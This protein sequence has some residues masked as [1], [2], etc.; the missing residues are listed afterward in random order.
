MRSEQSSVNIRMK[1]GELLLTVL[2]GAKSFV[3]VLNGGSNQPT[4]TTGFSP[5]QIR[6]NGSFPKTGNFKS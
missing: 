5:Q 1:F 4:D 2:Q 3:D 6:I